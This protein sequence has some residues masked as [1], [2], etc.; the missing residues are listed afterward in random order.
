MNDDM[1]EKLVRRGIDV[2]KLDKEFHEMA[3]ARRKMLAGIIRNV[4]IA[5]KEIARLDFAKLPEE[6]R[7]EFGALLDK[8]REQQN[9]ADRVNAATKNLDDWSFV[10]WHR[11]NA[12]RF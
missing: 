9:F 11:R 2:N 12:G 1:R 10:L 8:L 7:K 3:K 5:Y 6:E 4:K